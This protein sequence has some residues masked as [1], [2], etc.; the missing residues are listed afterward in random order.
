MGSS[1]DVTEVDRLLEKYMNRNVSNY[2]LVEKL[3]HKN[4]KDE[5]I[6]QIITDFNSEKKRIREFA[7]KV[8][9][10]LKSKYSNL[11]LP[12]QIQKINDYRRKYKFD[13]IK[14]DKIIF[15]GI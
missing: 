15:L 10:K 14:T 2:N 9:A 11:S 4:I 13:N 3:K 5:E 12:K 7:K 8:R 6:Q 1:T